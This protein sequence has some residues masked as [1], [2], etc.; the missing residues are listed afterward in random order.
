MSKIEDISLII[1]SF[2][3]ITGVGICFYDLKNFFMYIFPFFQI[4]Y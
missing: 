3:D 4:I 2:S 1:K